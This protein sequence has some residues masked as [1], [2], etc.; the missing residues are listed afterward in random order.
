MQRDEPLDDWSSAR[1]DEASRAHGAAAL[2]EAGAAETLATARQAQAAAKLSVAT[3]A[4][5]VAGALREQA[6]LSQLLA[7]ARADVPDEQLDGHLAEAERTLADAEARHARAASALA[8]ADPEALALE[9]R[10]ADGAER[11]IRADLEAL[12]RGKRDLEVELRALGRDGLGEQIAEVEERLAASRRRLAAQDGEARA[13]RLLHDI[14]AQAQRETRDRWL[15]PVRERAAPYLRLIQ[16]DSDIMLN[17]GTLEIEGLMRRGVNEPF[18][19]L[20]VGAREQVAV[21]TR[22]ALADILNGAK[23]PSAIIL[24]DALVNTDEERLH[25][26]HLVLQRAGQSMQIL[27][28]TCREQDFV[29]LGAPLKRL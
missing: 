14:L 1:L 10:R 11:A 26:M 22:L 29:Q 8:E 19:G 6:S 2:S 17:E 3:L 28:L 15:G 21:I 20:S 4:E 25:R 27:I 5:R 13:A 7:L 9:L 18:G 24:D 12:R 16:P 23:R